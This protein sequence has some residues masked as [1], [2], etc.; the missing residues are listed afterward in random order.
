MKVKTSWKLLIMALVG[1]L[2]TLLSNTEI[3]NVANIAISTFVFVITYFVSDMLYP[4]KSDAFTLAL[5]DFI[6]GSVLAVCMALSEYAG[7]LLSD[8]VFTWDAILKAALAAFLGYLTKTF[9]QK[10]N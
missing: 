7:I 1:F 4:S 10:P 6:K 2:A 9:F 5:Y 8:T 3:I